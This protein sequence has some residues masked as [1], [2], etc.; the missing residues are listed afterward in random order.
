M[1]MFFFIVDVSRIS[2]PAAC[3]MLM[4]PVVAME[5]IADDLVLLKHHGD[6]FGF[7]DASM[8]PVLS[9]ILTKGALE[10][11]GNPDAIDDQSGGFVAGAGDDL[12]A[13]RM[14]NRLCTILKTGD[15]YDHRR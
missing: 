10:V 2:T 13:M 15:R 1:A 14:Q 9:G 3:R 6:G 12:L 5:H 11:L 4:I 7:V 8:L